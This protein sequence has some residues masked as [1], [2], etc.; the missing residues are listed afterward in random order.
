[1]SDIPQGALIEIIELDKNGNVPDNPLGIIKPNTVRINGTQVF[2]RR[3]DGIEIEDPT[4]DPSGLVVTLR[5]YARQ[6]VLGEPL[7][8]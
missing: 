5:I 8:P 6:V 4:G 1:M 3:G 2:V 7:L